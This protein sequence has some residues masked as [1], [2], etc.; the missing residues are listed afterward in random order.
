MVI[1]A[2]GGL[3]AAGSNQLPDSSAYGG[4]AASVPTSD[5]PSG[6]APLT[7]APSHRDAVRFGSLTLVRPTRVNTPT[8]T[9]A[10]AGSL[11]RSATTAGLMPPGEVRT[12]S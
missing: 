2:S 10:S 6:G 11:R 7:G 9:S 8:D 4:S 1:T 12:A 3:V 5:G